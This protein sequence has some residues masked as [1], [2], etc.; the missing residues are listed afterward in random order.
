MGKY[1]QPHEGIAGT[2]RD[3]DDLLSLEEAMTGTVRRLLMIFGIYPYP[4]PGKAICIRCALNGRRT[5]RLD[6]DYALAHAKLHNSNNI[7][8]RIRVNYGVVRHGVG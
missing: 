3:G 7:P 6:A 2:L 4:E 5:L 1:P 8:L